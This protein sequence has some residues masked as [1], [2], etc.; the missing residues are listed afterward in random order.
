M[1]TTMAMK[2]PYILGQLQGLVTLCIMSFYNTEK[3]KRSLDFG[4]GY[5]DG[6]ILGVTILRTGKPKH[7]TG[8]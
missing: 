3:A 1:L 6:L 2:L 4:A 7:Q 8:M 5:G